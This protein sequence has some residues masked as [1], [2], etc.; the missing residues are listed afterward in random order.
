MIVVGRERE[1]GETERE[2]RGE[3]ER[4]MGRN[5]DEVVGDEGREEEMSEAA[6]GW[7]HLPLLKSLCFL[8][9]Y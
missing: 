3:R 4:E 7:D 5:F 1:R 8:L 6:G 9:F 2:K